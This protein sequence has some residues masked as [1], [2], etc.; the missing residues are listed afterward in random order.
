MLLANKG[1]VELV[2]VFSLPAIMFTARAITSNSSELATHVTK[3]VLVDNLTHF[4]R[5]TQD[6]L[7]RWRRVWC[8]RQWLQFIGGH[9]TFRMQLHGGKCS[10]LGVDYGEC[11]DGAVGIVQDVIL[12]ES[13]R[14]EEGEGWQVKSAPRR[15][16]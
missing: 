9:R 6:V 14:D 5:Q 7:L 3:V 8:C 16:D 4:Q 15:V 1:I 2:E 11:E 10:R 12:R 13:E